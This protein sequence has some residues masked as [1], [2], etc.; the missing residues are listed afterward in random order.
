MTLHIRRR[1]ISLFHLK[2]R[3]LTNWAAVGALYL[4]CFHANSPAAQRVTITAPAAAQQEVE[5]E[6]Y[7][8]LQNAGQLDQLL[9]QQY[10]AGSATYHKWLTPDQFRT[11][12]GPKQ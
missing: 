2:T 5:F 12:F 7:L 8:P 9:Q 11:Q 1:L 3:H 10:T 6:V 4:L